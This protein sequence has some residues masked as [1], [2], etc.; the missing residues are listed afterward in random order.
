MGGV[1]EVEPARG[2]G[3]VPESMA[4]VAEGRADE[5]WD[6]SNFRINSRRGSLSP[7]SASTLPL[8]V[9]CA[10]AICGILR[11]RQAVQL[12]C[13]SSGN[14]SR[15]M[16]ALAFRRPVPRQTSSAS[17]CICFASALVPGAQ[18]LMFASCG[19]S[20]SARFGSP[21]SKA[22]AEVCCLSLA[23]TRKGHVSQA[24]VVRAAPLASLF[25]RGDL[26]YDTCA[27]S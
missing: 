22:H 15:V 8:A 11:P 23:R 2:Q 18:P 17:V 5:G 1:P 10:A 25:F 3:C 24:V 4:R 7:S 19:L 20:N 9:V 6:G 26:E 27:V 12:S 21:L 14:A 16:S 13:I